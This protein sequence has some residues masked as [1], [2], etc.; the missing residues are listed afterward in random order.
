LLPSVF[1]VRGKKRKYKQGFLR[2]LLDEILCMHYQVP[3]FTQAS[4]FLVIT[5]PSPFLLNNGNHSFAHLS[6]LQ[7]HLSQG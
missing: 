2:M 4:S 5:V 3:N 6:L 7:F 1:T